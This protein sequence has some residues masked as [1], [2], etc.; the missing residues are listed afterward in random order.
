MTTVESRIIHEAPNKLEAFNPNF[1]F[2]LTFGVI[3][4]WQC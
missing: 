4:E 2:R 3:V 1:N